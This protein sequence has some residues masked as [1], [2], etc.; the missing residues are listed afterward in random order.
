MTPERFGP[1]RLDSLI[2]RGGMGEVLRA[3]DERRNRFVAV[4]RLLR[5]L[6][7]DQ[8]FRGRFQRESALAATLREPHIIP[9]HDYGEIDGLLFIDMRLVEGTDL[10]SVLKARQIAP[11]RAVDV[12]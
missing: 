2:G 7:S 4:K 11:E 8:E 1:Y 10:A 6:A 12:V 3:W 9:I 5:H